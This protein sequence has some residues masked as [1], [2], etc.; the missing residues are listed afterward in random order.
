MLY[1]VTATTSRG[2]SSSIR[3][4]RRRSVDVTVD[5]PHGDEDA[6]VGVVFVYSFSSCFADDVDGSSWLSLAQTVSLL[7]EVGSDLV[8]QNNRERLRRW[9]PS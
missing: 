1:V 2:L 3:R 4:R 9:P 6:W 5:A 7:M 8:K